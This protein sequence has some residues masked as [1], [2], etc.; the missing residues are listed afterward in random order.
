MNKFSAVY[1]HAEGSRFGVQL[2]A[3]AQ[4]CQLSPDILSHMPISVPNEP[5]QPRNLPQC[6]GADRSVF[7]SRLHR[8]ACFIGIC[9]CDFTAFTRRHHCR[10]CGMSACDA[11]SQAREIVPGADDPQRI[12]DRCKVGKDQQY[13][14]HTVAGTVLLAAV[15]PWQGIRRAC[16]GRGRVCASGASGEP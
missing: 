9:N 6:G 15:S 12:C 5:A 10:R 13:K 3:P 2:R 7:V 11:H 16:K 4:R 8:A 1:W 14:V